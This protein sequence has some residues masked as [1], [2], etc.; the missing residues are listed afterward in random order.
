[1]APGALGRGREAGS[2]QH[3]TA[4]S[5]AQPGRDVLGC[6][7]QQVTLGTRGG[8]AGAAWVLPVV[9]RLRCRRAAGT[10]GGS[11]LSGPGPGAREDQRCPPSLPG[12]GREFPLALRL[13]R[14]ELLAVAGAVQLERGSPA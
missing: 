1:M 12:S 8:D 13:K 11:L 7:K 2:G 5:V 10:L 4:C 3:G 6:S 14:G 9:F